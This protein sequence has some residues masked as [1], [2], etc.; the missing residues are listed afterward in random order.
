M[1]K[2][3]QMSMISSLVLI[4]SAVIV[5]AADLP[6][7]DAKILEDAGIPVYKGAEYVNGQL[8]GIMGLRL[9]T[10]ATLEEVRAFYRSEFPSWALNA[11]YGSWILYNG[12]P[13]SGPAA[14]MEKQQIMVAENKNLTEWFGIDKS[15]TTEIMIVVPE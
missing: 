6:A 9:A 7:K 4:L 15:K 3:L 5:L 12:E 11:E 8:G 10:S 13:G 1:K 14:Y 2:I